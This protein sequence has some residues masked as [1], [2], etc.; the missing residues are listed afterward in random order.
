MPWTL[1]KSRILWS[2]VSL[3]EIGAW[4]AWALLG[5]LPS[6]FRGVHLCPFMAFKRVI[7]GNPLL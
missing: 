1:T 6:C 4:P 7:D 5:R 2:N 3:V